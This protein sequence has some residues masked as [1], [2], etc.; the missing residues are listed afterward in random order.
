MSIS[1]QSRDLSLDEFNQSAG[2]HQRQQKQHLLSFKHYRHRH[3]AKGKYWA[4]LMEN[5]ITLETFSCFSQ[6]PC[7]LEVA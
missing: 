1:F 4:L 2:A 3:A 6:T 5:A 7:L